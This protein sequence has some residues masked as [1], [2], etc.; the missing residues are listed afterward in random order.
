MPIRVWRVFVRV[1]GVLVEDDLK[2]CPQDAGPLVVGALT[3]MDDNPHYDGPT[4]SFEIKVDDTKTVT[5]PLMR[6]LSADEYRKSLESPFCIDD[7]EVALSRERR[8]SENRVWLFRDALYVTDRSPR[9]PEFEEVILRV[10]ARH[11][12]EDVALQRLREQVANFEALERVSVGKPNRHTIPD[13]VKL[14]VWSRDGGACVRCRA[15]SDLHFDHIIPLIK[16]GGDHAEN[17]QILCRA[18]NL[19]KGRRIT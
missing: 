2:A 5:I 18:C 9:T 3:A 11:F 13:D 4:W 8:R 19:S 14:L 12:Q 16:G 15:R 7:L 17:I 10:K 1:E 6:F